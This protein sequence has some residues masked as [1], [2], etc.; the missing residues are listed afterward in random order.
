MIEEIK[1]MLDK[2]FFLM[3][4]VSVMVFLAMAVFIYYSSIAQNN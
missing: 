4:G 1:K 3:I 2:E